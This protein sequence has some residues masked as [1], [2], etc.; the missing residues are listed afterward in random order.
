[1][2]GHSKWANIK[3]RKGAA[4]AKKGKV[5]SRLAKEI[6]VSVKHGG[7]DVSANTR[8]RTALTA[9]RNANMPRDNIDR[10]I[11]KGAGESGES[12]NYESIFY[13]GWCNGFAILAECLTE[14][15]N[16]TASDVRML[17]DRGNGTL[18]GGGS[19]TRLFH[20][21]AHFVVKGENADE[22]KLM[23]IVLDA[24]ADDIEVDSGVAEIWGPQEAYDAIS[25]ALENAKIA[26][27]ES[28][29]VQKPDTLMEVTEPEIAKR[30]LNLIETLE[31]YDDIQAVYTNIDIP[32]EVLEK[33]AAEQEK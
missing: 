30:V 24:G 20:R 5:F 8:L 7:K 22:D 25:K 27:E 26:T 29:I 12:V 33:L 4:D 2:S 3:H 18:A 1:M 13:E 9:A 32:D 17:Y 15:K 10:A 31:E 19:V 28:G 21:K 23:N 11:K 16:R 14:N 6:M